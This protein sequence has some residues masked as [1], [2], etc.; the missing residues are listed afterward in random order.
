[1]FHERSI[2]KTDFL[3][4]QL[5]LG[6]HYHSSIHYL[7][8]HAAKNQFKRIQL[9]KPRQRANLNSAMS[10]EICVADPWNILF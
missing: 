7:D 2:W 8:A 3:K 4:L 6:G 9:R 1:M 10:P 5:A